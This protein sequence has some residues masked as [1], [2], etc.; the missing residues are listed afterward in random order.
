MKIHGTIYH[1]SQSYVIRHTLA[2]VIHTKKKQSLN[3]TLWLESPVSYLLNPNLGGLF[4]GLCCSE[5]GGGGVELA[6]NRENDND[7]TNCRHDVILNF[8]R[9]PC[10][11][12]QG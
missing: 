6:I 10:F 11:S 1:I 4:R 8:L 9:L 2:Q 7:V 3:K 5:E 12:S